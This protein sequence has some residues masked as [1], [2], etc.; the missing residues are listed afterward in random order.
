MR[1]VLIA[2]A[3]LIVIGYPGSAQNTDQA[4]TPPNVTFDRIL[5]AGEEPQNRLT[6]SGNL[7][8]HRHSALTH[9]T[10][11]NVKDLEIAWLRQAP[12]NGFLEAT[13]LVVDG[14]MYTTRNT[15]AIPIV[16]PISL[17]ENPF[18]TSSS[19]GARHFCGRSS[20]PAWDLPRPTRGPS[21]RRMPRLCIVV[22][23]S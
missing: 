2:V 1:R 8:G 18:A 7:Q 14:A 12:T 17:F 15:N 3:I 13:P 10:R 9:I 6:Y 23:K 19:K 21:G 4:G 22:P 16:N 20:S 5:R 11:E